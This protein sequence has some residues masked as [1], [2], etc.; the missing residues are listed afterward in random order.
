MT[1]PAGT[2]GATTAADAAPVGGGRLALLLQEPLTAATRLRT[3]RQ[4]VTDA[5][6]FRE[7]MLQLLRRADADAAASGYDR[8][9]IRLAIF[10]VVALLDESALASPQPAFGEWARRPMQQEMFGG[11]LAGEWFFQHIDELLSRPDSA[12]LADLLEVYDLCLLL[13][14]RGRYSADA[15]ALYSVASRVSERVARMR[16]AAPAQE[17][18]PGWRPPNDVIAGRDP[19]LRRLVVG[20]VAAVVLA[21]LVWGVGA[22]SLRSGQGEL[23]TLARPASVKS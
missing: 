11:L 14:F 19:W 8:A 20:L 7:R 17:L 5:G 6:A 1:H 15:G 16:G 12:Q 18:V 3:D 22:L 9:D 13:G 2:Q 23:A 21:V 4:P 10:A